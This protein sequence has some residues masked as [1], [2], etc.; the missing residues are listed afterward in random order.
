MGILSW[1]FVGMVAGWLA[2]MVIKGEGFGCI[3]NTIVG[4]IGAVFGGWM[5]S[6]FLNVS[7]PVTGFNLPSILVAF[8]GAV[9]FVVLVRLVRRKSA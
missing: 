6:F 2:G 5:T 1:I 7:D 9:V 4:I 8:V 3:G